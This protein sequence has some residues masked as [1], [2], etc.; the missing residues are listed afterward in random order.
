MR[1]LSLLRIFMPGVLATLAVGTASGSPAI[2][3]VPGGIGQTV[4]LRYQLNISAADGPRLING[5]LTLTRITSSR[6]AVTLTPDDDQ[7][8][9]V[10]VAIDGD[11]RLGAAPAPLRSE[12]PPIIG[13]APTATNSVAETAAPTLPPGLREVVALLISAPP[14]ATGSWKFSLARA[15]SST[16][17]TPIPSSIPQSPVGPIAMTAYAASSSRDELTFIADGSTATTLRPSDSSSADGYRR[18]GGGGG[19]IRRIANAAANSVPPAVSSEPAAPALLTLHI[20]TTLHSGTFFAARGT[21]R[22]VA[23]RGGVAPTT[24]SWTLT[25]FASPSPAPKPTPKKH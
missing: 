14:S 11:G 5:I 7:P 25:A 6:A 15:T 9:V 13:P 20:E 8:F 22:S 12:A 19:P 18:R 4:T 24:T 2:S 21:E 1:A 23:Q 10:D 17:T 3:F 16:E